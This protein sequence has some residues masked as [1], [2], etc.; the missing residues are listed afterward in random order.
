MRGFQGEKLA[1]SGIE[2]TA[3]SQNNT[4]KKIESLFGKHN[5]SFLIWHSTLNFLLQHPTVWYDRM[6]SRYSSKE[7]VLSDFLHEGST[8]VWKTVTNSTCTPLYQWTSGKS[9]LVIPDLKT[10][11][12][13]QLSSGELWN[14]S[15]S[16]ACKLTRSLPRAILT[17]H[18]PG[19]QHFWQC[20]FRF[21]RKG[22]VFH[23]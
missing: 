2:S 9:S 12:F 3:V 10:A 13:V 19:G 1:K 20:Y 17:F 8:A 18:R 16:T 11:F 23:C 15:F 21:W 4:T 5:F 7:P 6:P 14:V 22:W